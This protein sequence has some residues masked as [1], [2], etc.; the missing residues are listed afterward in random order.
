MQLDLCLSRLIEEIER[1]NRKV[2]QPFKIAFVHSSSDLPEYCVSEEFSPQPRTG[3]WVDQSFHMQLAQEY[4]R[5]PSVHDGALALRYS[6]TRGSLTISSWGVRL[7][8]PV[9]TCERGLNRGMA[10]NSSLHFSAVKGVER[11]VL[12][13]ASG[14]MQFRGGRSLD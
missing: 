9:L 14:A 2:V 7:F 13:G 5:N 11:V 4:R 12:F 8:P 10:Y 6:S 1:H 3:Y